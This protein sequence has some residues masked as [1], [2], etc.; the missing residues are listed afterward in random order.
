MS[1]A[2]LCPGQGGQHPR[3]FER[4][5]AAP[6]A[7]PLLRAA[8]K[9]LGRTPQALAGDEERYR[10]AIAQPL[11]CAAALAHWRALQ[12]LL[13]AR[14]LA[15]GYSVGELA[16]HAIA[17][18]FDDATCLQLA[19]RRA[20]LM[21]AASPADA[22]LLAVVG[23]PRSA[24]E[25][26]LHRYQAALA[27][28]NGEDHAVLGGPRQALDALAAEAR[29]QGAR[30]CP[31]PVSVPA[32]TPWLRAAAD[33]FAQELDRASL[34]APALAVL[35]GVDAQPARTPAR[36][37]DTLA[38]QIATTVRWRQAMAQALERGATVFLELGPGSAL[39]RMAR[40]LAPQAE[41]RSVEDFQTLEGVA[42]WVQR[43]C[44]R[45]ADSGV[46]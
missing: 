37:R 11:V 5:L 46:S 14:G 31:L 40:E 15:L 25:T 44:A 8:R 38:A 34:R 20:A 1:L 9:T 30:A 6:A 29:A 17:G 19:A 42:E 43:A 26:L 28:D 39:A 32:H 27:I 12:P 41:A 36:V 3:M 45:A 2:L 16:A 21:D 24:L 23:L 18:S 13:P 35:A 7:A 4:V 22:G 33:G 10:N